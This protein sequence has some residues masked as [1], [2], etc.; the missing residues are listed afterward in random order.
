L[1]ARS[2]HPVKDSVLFVA[3]AACIAFG[4]TSSHPKAV[5]QAPTVGPVAQVYPPAPSYR[6][7]DGQ[8]YVFSVEWH[9]FN[10]GIARVSMD[11]SGAQRRV[12]AIADSLGVVNLMYT[13]HDRFE[14]YFDPRTFC[15]QK[16]VKHSEEGK[17]RRDTEIQFEYPRRKAVLSEKNLK[18]GENRRVESDIPGC[19]TDVVTGFYYL[20]SQPL[21][22]G[23][24][25]TF[26]IS[27]G[28]KTTIVS[29]RVETVEQL[30]VPAGIYQAVR[31]VAEPIS[32][33]L[34]GKGKVAVW[35]SNDANHT[36]LQ[37]RAK[38]GWGTL[39]FRLQRVE[40]K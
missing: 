36:P 1:I 6:F 24:S 26:P 27:D 31:V 40:K 5:D 2:R 19:V 28:G 39:L 33:P 17:R 9:M 22:A 34:K 23:S 11:T 16:I 30:K 13:V 18:T 20:A 35:F 7:P 21:T 38:L 25:Y 10:A 15:S 4:Q 32:G 37:M 8:T 14:S 3:I 12:T 29:A